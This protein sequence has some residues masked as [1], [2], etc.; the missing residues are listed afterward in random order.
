MHSAVVSGQKQSAL[1]QLLDELVQ[2]RA[3]DP[4]EAT[5]A[6]RPGD[7]IAGGR[8]LA[9]AEQYPL[10]RRLCADLCR[11]LGET[12]RQPALGRPVLRARA[13]ADFYRRSIAI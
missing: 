8:V 11:G 1:A 9:G 6:Q 2:R 3:A 13:K 12:L 10:H 7:L 4:V 5:L